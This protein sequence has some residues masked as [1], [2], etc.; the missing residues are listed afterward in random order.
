LFDKE[1]CFFTQDISV[2]WKL[3]SFGHEVHKFVR[4]I[5]NLKVELFGKVNVVY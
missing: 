3:A 5:L 2:K 1:S 4:V